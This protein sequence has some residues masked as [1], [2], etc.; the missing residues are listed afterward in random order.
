[1]P[2]FAFFPHHALM[3]HAELHYLPHSSNAEQ[4]VLGALLTD[5]ERIIEVAPHLTPADFYD[6]VYRTI[7]EAILELYEQRSPI[8]AVTVAARLDGH[9]TI[10][11]PFL[12]ELEANVPTASHARKYA[13]I[14]RDKSLRRRLIKV[15]EAIQAI[16]FDANEKT[17]STELLESAEQRLLALSH[18]ST[19]AKPK[20]LADIAP[21]R[22]ERYTAL[23]EADDPTEH[24]G[25]RTGFVDI[26]QLITGLQPGH[27]LVLAARPSMG[28]TALALDVARNVASEG[29]IV[30]IFSLEMTQ[31]EL[32]D[33]IFSTLLSI[34]TWR[35]KRGSLSEEEYKQM[36]TVFDSLKDHRIFIDDD[37]D[38]TL[39]NLRSKARRQQMEHGLD[40][41][42]I[43]YLQL[44]E[45]TDRAAGENQTQRISYISRNLKNL[46]RELHCPIIA[47]SQLSRA[48]EQR[49]P[50]TPI[51]SD[52]RDS[53]A[54]EQDA[55]SVLMLY[56]QGYYDPDCE[57]PDLTDLYLRKNRQGPTGHV[58]LRFDGKQMSFAP[59]ANL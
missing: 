3:S 19:D 25:I 39:A 7:Y 20:Q 46:A 51:L 16:A 49:T 33:R 38:T 36:G 48:V 17:P 32:A 2:F 12:I 45:V 30:T 27:L 54:I 47:L 23:Y 11:L 13:E 50:P 29:R 53:G 28:K 22:Y 34:E 43:D 9:S 35:L 42:I 5:P 37:P 4:T 44:I 14:V 24:F 8:D 59:V 31:A 18:Q 58:E 57:Q 21:E 55:D 41:L 40:L 15:G 1:M 56:R 10:C 26:D 52:L 6:G